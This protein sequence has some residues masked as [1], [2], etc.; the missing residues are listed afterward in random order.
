MPQIIACVYFTIL[1]ISLLLVVTHVGASHRTRYIVKPFSYPFELS[2][3]YYAKSFIPS[4]NFFFH[5]QQ[6]LG[7]IARRTLIVHLIYVQFLMLFNAFIWCV[8]V[9]QTSSS[10]EQHDI[11]SIKDHDL[12]PLDYYVIKQHLAQNLFFPFFFG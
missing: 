2:C 8:F 5:S 10:M 7:R 6:R 12:K 1:L 4:S 3:L 9:F 11:W